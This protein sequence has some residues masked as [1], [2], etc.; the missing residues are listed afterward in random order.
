MRYN[1]RPHTVEAFKFIGKNVVPPKW[2]ADA[3]KI[4]KASVTINLR[5]SY[6]TLFNNKDDMERAYIGHWVCMNNSG[7]LFR[8]SDDEFISSYYLEDK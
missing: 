8:I 6:I 2:F 4:G 3:V 1:S 5:E 7:K